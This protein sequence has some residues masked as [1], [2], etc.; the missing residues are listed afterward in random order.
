MLFTGISRLTSSDS[1]FSVSCG[2]KITAETGELMSPGYPDN[3]KA[4]KKC[5]WDITVPEVRK[6]RKSTFH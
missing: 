1:C 6:H 5:K 4:N 2:G 3:Y